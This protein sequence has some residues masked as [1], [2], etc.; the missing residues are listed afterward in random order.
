DAAEGIVKSAEAYNG[1][2][3]INLGSGMEISIRELIEL[4]AELTG[5]E[6][7]IV[8]DESRPDGQPRRCLDVSRAEK[9][10]G[11]R[12]KTDFREGLSRTIRWFRKGGNR[13]GSSAH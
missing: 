4:I 12:A 2:E 3:P 7:K 1:S 8:W 11:F 6:G 10:F 13:S 5:F 9:E